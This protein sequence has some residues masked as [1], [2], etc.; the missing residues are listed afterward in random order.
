MRYESGEC[1]AHTERKI[2]LESFG[3]FS[4]R[5]PKN[6]LGSFWAYS[7]EARNCGDGMLFLE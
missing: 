4:I 1:R 5:D 7:Q 3:I 6:F 2:Q